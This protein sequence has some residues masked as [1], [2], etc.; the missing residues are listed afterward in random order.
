VF[1]AGAG[2]TGVVIALPTPAFVPTKQAV[3]GAVGL[4]TLQLAILAVHD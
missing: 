1:N 3:D 4:Y 2:A